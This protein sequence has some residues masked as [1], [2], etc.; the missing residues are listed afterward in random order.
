MVGLYSSAILFTKTKSE[1]KM[2]GGA[3]VGYFN[4]DM[5]LLLLETETTVV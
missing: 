5:V 4:L 3:I 1:N 2:I